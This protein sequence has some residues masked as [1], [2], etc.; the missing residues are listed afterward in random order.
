MSISATVVCG[1]TI[2]NGTSRTLV[3]QQTSKV[4][5][6]AGDDID[7]GTFVVPTTAGGTAIAF[8]AAMGSLGW[9]TVENLDTTNYVELGRQVAG[10]FYAFLRVPPE[11]KIGPFYFG[12]GAS[13]VYALAN[14]GSVRINIK[15][16]E[17]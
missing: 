13:D 3:D 4:H 15:V 7:S 2:T 5:V 1:M 14:T 10:T 6:V 12:C 11:T 17:R 9:A 16:A 8:K